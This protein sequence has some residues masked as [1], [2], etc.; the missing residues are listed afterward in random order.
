MKIL[1]KIGIIITSLLISAG[2]VHALPEQM[3]Q[4]LN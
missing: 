3:I 2:A 4:T 1:K